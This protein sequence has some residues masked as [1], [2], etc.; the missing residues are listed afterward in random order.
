MA[1]SVFVIPLLSVLLVNFGTAKAVFL[2][3]SAQ[4][5]LTGTE[6]PAVLLLSSV[7]RHQME[8]NSLLC[9]H[10][11]MSSR[12]LLERKCMCDPDPAMPSRNLLEWNSLCDS[13]STMP[14]GNLLE[15]KCLCDSDPTMSPR[16]LLEW[17]SLCDSKSTM[18]SGNLLERKCLRNSDSAVPSGNLLERK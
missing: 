11:Y 14:S 3:A 6:L 2:Q 4:L 13:N 9:H 8:W 10:N 7:P 12:N 1:S 5:E 17:N 16:N 18:P 15:R